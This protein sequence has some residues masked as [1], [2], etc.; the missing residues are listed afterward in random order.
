MGCLGECGYHGCFAT[1]AS[2]MATSVKY[3]WATIDNLLRLLITRPTDNVYSYAAPHTVLFQVHVGHSHMCF[4]SNLY[5]PAC[6][7]TCKQVRGVCV[8]AHFA[9]TWPSSP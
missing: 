8:G 5:L 9:N 7:L 2:E 4:H 3:C 6:L 1:R